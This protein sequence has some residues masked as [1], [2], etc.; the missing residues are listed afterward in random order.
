MLRD[1]ARRSHDSRR[2]M[3]ANIIKRA[4]FMISPANNNQRLARQIKS[5]KLPCIGDLVRASYRDPVAAEHLFALQPPDP[6]IHIP[7]S[8]DRGSVLQR[9][10]LIIKRQHVSKRLV[11]S[12]IP[13]LRAVA[14]IIERCPRQ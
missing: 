1:P 6:L 7:R 3:A 5:K 10:L 9:R 14:R 13:S 8:R 11:H 12:A 2:M 4:Q